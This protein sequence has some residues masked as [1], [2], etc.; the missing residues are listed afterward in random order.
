M[1]QLNR[2]LEEAQT[3][4]DRGSSDD[5]ERWN[6]MIEQLRAQIEK[7]KSRTEARIEQIRSQSGSQP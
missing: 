6:K 5:T 7:E 1:A 3:A 2:Q 4:R